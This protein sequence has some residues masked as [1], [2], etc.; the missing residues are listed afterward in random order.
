MCEGDW[1][2][3]RSVWQSQG[4][5]EKGQGSG[6]GRERGRQGRR[7]MASRKTEKKSGNM[8]HPKPSLGGSQ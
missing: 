2:W 3:S 7:R 1:P 4:A 5:E 8:W 6:S